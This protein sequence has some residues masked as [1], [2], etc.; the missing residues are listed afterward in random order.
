MAFS[1]TSVLLLETNSARDQVDHGDGVQVGAVKPITQAELGHQHWL[2]RLDP[3]DIVLVKVDE[4][5][6]EEPELERTL[7]CLPELRHHAL[8]WDLLER[9]NEEP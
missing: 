5:W 6:E 8:L 7:H 9:P 4:G 3:E 1:L 2:H